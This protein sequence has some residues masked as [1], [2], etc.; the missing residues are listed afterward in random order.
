MYWF[1]CDICVKKYLWC[2]LFETQKPKATD[3]DPAPA[4]HKFSPTPKDTPSIFSPYLSPHCS[5]QKHQKHVS[6]RMSLE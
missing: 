4:G 6:L 1:L 2:A 5:W 3:I